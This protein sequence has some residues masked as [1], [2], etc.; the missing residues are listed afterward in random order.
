MDQVKTDPRIL[1]TRKLIVDSF[2]N[3][4]QTKSFN[5]ISVTD[6]TREAMI[7]RATFYNHFLD[8]YDL[9]EQMIAERLK[10]NL[11]C[12]D[13]STESSLENI[14]KQL[15][16]SLTDFEKSLKLKTENQEE[17]E[18]I[19]SR[20]HYEIFSIFNEELETRVPFEDKEAMNRLAT[21]FTNNVLTMSKEWILVKE[22]ETPEKYIESLLPVIKY[23]VNGL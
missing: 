14:I 12:S 6:I 1:R 15:F 20:I 17:I 9:L 18:L 19:H 16:F 2:E 21:Y 13:Q 11:N 10:T 23:G 8:K 7:N 5:D 3:L 22:N 4:T